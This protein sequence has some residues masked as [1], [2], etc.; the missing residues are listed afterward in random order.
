MTTSLGPWF[1]VHVIQDGWPKALMLLRKSRAK[2]DWHHQYPAFDSWT[3][4]VPHC[5][6]LRRSSPPPNEVPCR[7]VQS[8]LSG[9]SGNH[10]KTAHDPTPLARATPQ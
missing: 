10:M 6:L 2:D 7:Q 4:I 1:D 3:T 9:W 5:D 8:D